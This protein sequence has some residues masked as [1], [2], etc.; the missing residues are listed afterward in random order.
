[1]TIEE[2]TELIRLVKETQIAELEVTRGDSKVRITSS[3]PAV[4]EVFVPSLPPAGG[5]GQLAT[6]LIAP[7]E[8]SASEPHDVDAKDITVKSP[9]VGTYYDSPG[10]GEPAFVKVG[11]KIEPK[12]VLCIIE[13]M[14]L[15]NEIEAESAG[16]IV[17]KLVENG[18]PVEYGQALFTVRLSA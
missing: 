12:Q 14:K 4:Q 8:S 10:E 3:R 5:L 18:K 15:M 6:P 16:V 1:M 17:S 7:R 13:S 2:I 11:D 9:I